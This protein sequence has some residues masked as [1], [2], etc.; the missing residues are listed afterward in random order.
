MKE[1]TNFQRTYVVLVEVVENY[2]KGSISFKGNT[3]NL[4]VQFLVKGT[5]G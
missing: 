4:Y 1:K 2:E 3:L 5:S